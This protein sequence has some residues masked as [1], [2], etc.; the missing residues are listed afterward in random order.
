MVKIRLSRFG[1][2]KNPYY[3]IVAAD[4]Q[5]ARDC[6]FLEQIGVYDPKKPMTEAK[7]N[8]DRLQY[9]I[10]VGAQLSESVAKVVR[11]QSKVAAA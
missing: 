9:W 8:K 6:K 5:R 2:K 3:H 7:L 4:S 1:S 11:E 10:G